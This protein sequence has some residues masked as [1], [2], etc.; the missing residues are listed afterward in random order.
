[1]KLRLG[2]RKKQISMLLGTSLFAG[3][4]SAEITT[5]QD[6]ENGLRFW[7][8]THDGVSVQ[9]LQ[10]LPDQT[11]AFFLGRGFGREEA[12]RI[13]RSCVFQTIFR[14]R[15]WRADVGRRRIACADPSPLTAAAGPPWTGCRRAA[16]RNRW[17]TRHARPC[18][19]VPQTM[20]GRVQEPMPVWRPALSSGG[21]RQGQGPDAQ[22]GGTVMIPTDFPKRINPAKV[23]FSIDESAH[24]A[25]GRPMRREMETR[26]GP[27]G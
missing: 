18:Q 19:Q 9:L 16:P 10:L 15:D 2:R 20:D 8:W 23:R 26:N 27:A 3:M 11:R 7:T 12:D 14:S 5:G 17:H 4:V 1:M 22:D 6:Q 25:L 21:R 24:A 13:G